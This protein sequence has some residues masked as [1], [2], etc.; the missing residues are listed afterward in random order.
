MLFRLPQCQLDNS[1]L[2]FCW[3]HRVSVLSQP[4]IYCHEWSTSLDDMN[5]CPSCGC[6]CPRSGAKS[7]LRSPCIVSGIMSPLFTILNVWNMYLSSGDMWS[8]YEVSLSIRNWLMRCFVIGIM[9]CDVTQSTLKLI[10]LLELLYVVS[11]HCHVGDDNDWLVSMLMFDWSGW[12][13]WHDVFFFLETSFFG[14]IVWSRDSQQ[15]PTGFEGS[16]VSLLS[17]TCGDN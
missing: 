17:L 3:I 16:C 1:A 14:A 6:V 8:I 11:L 12:P 2:I 10:C 5:F 7:C 15:R 13:H 4:M 9:S